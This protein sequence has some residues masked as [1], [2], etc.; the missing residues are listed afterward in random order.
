MKRLGFFLA[1]A[2]ALLLS[3]TALA[4]WATSQE[5]I[6]KHPT[7]IYTPGS[8]LKNSQSH[9]LLVVLHGC[10]QTNSD[11]KEFGNLE[12]AAEDNGL[13]LAVPFVGEKYFGNEQQKCWDYNGADD[14]S[15]HIK[16]I[17]ALA[18]E[19]KSRSE[20][21]IDSKQVYVVGLSS[22]ASLSLLLGCSAPDLFSGI[23]ALAGPSVGSNQYFAMNEGSMIPADNVSEA[24]E[25]CKA[26]S[27]GKAGYLEKQIAN[28]A[29]GDMD[30]N[31][32]KDQ[33]PYFGGSTGHPGQYSVVSTKWSK[34]NV[35]ALQEIYGT[36]ELGPPT[37]VQGGK[38]DEQSARARTDGATRLSLLV[39]HDVGHAWA[40][41]TGKPNSVNSGGLWIAQQGL[42]YPSYVAQWLVANNRTNS[43][44][45]LK[46]TKA[47]VSGRSVEIGGTAEDRDPKDKVTEVSVMLDGRYPQQARKASGVNAWSVSFSN[48]PND[49]CY[50]PVAT[51][52]DSFGGLASATGAPVKLGNPPAGRPLAITVDQASVDEESQCINVSGTAAS[53][54]GR[55]KKVEVKL[56]D[57]SFEP[58]V[59]SGRNYA[60]QACGLPNSTYTTAVRATDE[61]GESVQVSGATIPAYVRAVS[62]KLSDHILSRRLRLYSPPCANNGMGACDE[63]LTSIV[64]KYP[65]DSFKLFSPGNDI[66]YF[67]RENALPVDV[68][69]ASIEDLQRL[70]GI[71][72]SRA[73][74]IVQNRPYEIAEQLVTR[75]IIPK[76]V[77]EANKHR[78]FA[79]QKQQ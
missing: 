33:F 36:G 32:P 47:E 10:A 1:L 72:P 67:Y 16:E 58:A 30:K 24:I 68:N 19:L 22:G 27:G 60:Y 56:G 9:G 41:G 29:Y 78:I 76:K 62:S 6:Q 73:R 70:D 48:L 12:K 59:L 54:C 65:Y 11:L 55:V 69:S 15:G 7:W 8:T 50:T 42:A 61:G 28:I 77:Y 5:V 75:H 45:D 23:G 25:T 49:A 44:P 37:D 14:Y 40:A 79:G 46:I 64:M 43:P 20:L 4:G 39:V 51:A 13:V 31:G 57:R 52:R 63:T 2:A 26:L 71:G 3:R 66:W 21:K 53:E 34:D 35:Q 38:G 18:R 17:T 74:S